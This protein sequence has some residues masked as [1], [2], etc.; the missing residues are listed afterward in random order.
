LRKRKLTI[1]VLLLILVFLFNSV[2]F[3]FSINAK[4][5]VLMDPVTGQVLYGQNEHQRLPPASVTK[6]MTMLLILEAIDQGRAKWNDMIRTSAKAYEMGGSQVYLK[7][8]EEFPLHEM[9]KAIA[10]VSAND[11]SAAVAEYL[12]GSVD[13]FVEAMN[14]RAKSLGLKDTHFDNE[15]G[16]PDPAHYSSAYDLAVISRE[17]IIKHPVV[18]KYTS[19]WLDT[20]RNGKFM[21][22]NTNELL[23]EYRGCDGLKTGHT[24]EAGFCLSATAK[25][26]DFR[27]LSVIL[28]TPTDTQRVEQSKRILDYGFRTFQWKLIQKTGV[29]GKVFIPGASPERVPVQLKSNF[30]VLVPRGNDQLI[31]TRLV[32]NQEIKL[33]V[34]AGQAIASLKAYVNGKLIAEVPA[35]S[36]VKVKPSNFIVRWW[37][38]LLDFIHGLFVRKK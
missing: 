32:R 5:A 1:F 13:D 4:A 33:P 35:Y 19:I 17:L 10:V 38:M 30:G 6:V 7:E 36:T 37:R 27:L 34:P 22:R 2:T 15:T 21:L 26:G 9:F 29:V 12:Y 31:R 3:G 25:K 28:G 16:L 23:K 20:F 24:D 14:N 18:L 8:G 11:A